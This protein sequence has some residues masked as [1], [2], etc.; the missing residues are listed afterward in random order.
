MANALKTCSAAS[1]YAP[2]F[3]PMQA[4]KASGDRSI[5]ASWVHM[6]NLQATPTLYIARVYVGRNISASRYAPSDSSGLFPFESDEPK[7]FHNR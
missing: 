7:R 6:S 1:L 3:R 5:T 4:A 2:M